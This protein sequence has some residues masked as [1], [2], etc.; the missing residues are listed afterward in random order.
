MKEKESQ[1]LV[2]PGSSKSRSTIHKLTVIPG[3]NSQIIERLIALL[4]KFYEETTNLAVDTSEFC[5]SGC[6]LYIL[7][8]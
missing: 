5:L 4:W 8:H 6:C 7:G 3:P 2:L 1:H